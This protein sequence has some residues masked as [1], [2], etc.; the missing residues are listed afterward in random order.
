MLIFFILIGA[1]AGFS[2]DGVGGIVFGAAIGVVLG[3]VRQMS[4]RVAALEASE[5][6]AERVTA[7]VSPIPEA[8]NVPEE[9]AATPEPPTPETS[10]DPP[11]PPTEERA[12]APRATTGSDAGTTERTLSATDR[13]TD[14]VRGWLTSG[15]VP[16]RVGVLLSLLGLAF[17]VHEAIDQQL[18]NLPIGFR[19]V[20]VATF[21]RGLL[22]VGW[23]L[24][25]R[26]RAYALSLQ[27]GGVAEF[28]KTQVGANEV[29]RATPGVRCLDQ[30]LQN[31]QRG[32]LNSV[33]P[34]E[35]AVTRKPLYRWHH[36]QH[37]TVMR[38]QGRPGGPVV[39]ARSARASRTSD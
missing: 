29:A 38:H 16:V 8:V 25:D 35:F 11:R 3:W 9:R 12:H 19:L 20:G 14:T 2:L 13:V 5:A 31:V 32:R 26:R 4:H 33:A 37:E 10:P 6:A 36:P 28:L 30:P 21:G 15:N 17:F 7:P 22:L 34:Q 23:R 1:F 39:L 24:R 27:G 18:F